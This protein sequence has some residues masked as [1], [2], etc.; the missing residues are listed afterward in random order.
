MLSE[1]QTTLEQKDKYADSNWGIYTTKETDFKQ[2]SKIIW[3]KVALICKQISN[4]V[5]LNPIFFKKIN[6]EA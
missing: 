6:Y 1:E 2:L 5:L 3:P 4:T